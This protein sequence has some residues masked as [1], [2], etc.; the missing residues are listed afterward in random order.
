MEKQSDG[1][2]GLEK[3]PTRIFRS[4]VEGAAHVAREIAELIRT[5]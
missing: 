4:S 5:K 3:V 2:P 1:G